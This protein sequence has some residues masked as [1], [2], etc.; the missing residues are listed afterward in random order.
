MPLV[1]FKI[2]E[3]YYLNNL[4][5]IIFIFDQYDGYRENI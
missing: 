5:T 3:N 2:I 4:A 1:Y